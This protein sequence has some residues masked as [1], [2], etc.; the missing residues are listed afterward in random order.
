L[1]LVLSTPHTLM[2]PDAYIPEIRK[3]CVE[4]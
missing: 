2:K 1:N 3:V 4:F